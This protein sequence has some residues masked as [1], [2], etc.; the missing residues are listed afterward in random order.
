MDDRFFFDVGK[1]KFALREAHL[2]EK[3][4]RFDVMPFGVRQDAIEPVVFSSGKLPK[5][6]KMSSDAAIGEE[7]WK[8]TWTGGNL[9]IASLMK[10]PFSHAMVFGLEAG[11]LSKVRKRERARAI[12]RAA[13]QVALGNRSPNQIAELGSGAYEVTGIGFVWF[14]Q[15]GSAIELQSQAYFR[16]PSMNRDFRWY[17]E[18][19]ASLTETRRLSRQQNHEVFLLTI[20]AFGGVMGGAGGV[21]SASSSALDKGLAVLDKGLNQVGVKT[22]PAGETFTETLVKVTSSGR[23]EMRIQQL[24]RSPVKAIRKLKPL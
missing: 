11:W 4:L 21:G 23:N 2:T 9:K 19:G 13:P 17:L 1:F 16:T 5:N 10:Q 20:A 22:R 3:Y 14:G 24:A 12:W 18:R 8:I 6:C 7:R 15:E